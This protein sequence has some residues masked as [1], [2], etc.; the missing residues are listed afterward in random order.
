VQSKLQ[1]LIDSFFKPQKEEQADEE[2]EGEEVPVPEVDPV[3]LQSLTNMGFPDVACKK[4]LIL[5][6]GN[7]EQSMEWIL[8]HSEDADFNEP[9]TQRQLRGLGLGGRRQ[10]EFVPHPVAFQRLTEMGF[11]EN[12]VTEA[13]RMTNNDHEAAA[14]YLLGDRVERVGRGAREELEE[15]TA[16]PLDNP[17]IKA[18]LENPAVQSGMTNP[19]VIEAFQR[20]MEDPS[21]A[22]EYLRDPQIG[23]ILMQVNQVMSTTPNNPPA[24]DTMYDEE[25][26]DEEEDDDTNI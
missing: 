17:I 23:P 3:S 1:N 13:L 5:H 20:I 10:T 14:A 2:G 26:G 11:D 12:Q 24:D 21:T 18:L 6:N 8:E 9:I 25:E 4:A 16:F 22:A 7:A 15:Q 19:R